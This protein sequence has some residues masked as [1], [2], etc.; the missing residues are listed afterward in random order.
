MIQLNRDR[1]LVKW[2]YMG[3]NPPRATTI[4]VLFW[5]TVLV[6]PSFLFLVVVLF[7]LWG[8]ALFWNEF[9]E[10]P[11]LRWKR[12]RKQISIDKWLARYERRLAKK[13]LKGEPSVWSVL[14]SD[15]KTIKG[16]V[17]PIVELVD[18]RESNKLR[19]PRE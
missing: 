11:F 5:R 15:L 14:W 1:K 18:L 9:C 8:P 2:A 6:I 7:P 3:I 13:R 17:C 4:C 12:R 16:K 10:Q 19:L